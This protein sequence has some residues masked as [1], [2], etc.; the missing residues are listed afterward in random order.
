MAQPAAA[1]ASTAGN[2]KVDRFM[3]FGVHDDTRPEDEKRPAPQGGPG[4]G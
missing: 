3:A 4:V 2:R 1:A